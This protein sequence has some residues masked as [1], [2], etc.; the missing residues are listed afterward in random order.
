MAVSRHL[1]VS[2]A[3]G[4]LS[5]LLLT[6]DSSQGHAYSLCET[7]RLQLPG[8]P[9]WLGWDDKNAKHLVLDEA[10][11]SGFI[12]V[13]ASEGELNSSSIVDQV[14]APPGAVACCSYGGGRYLAIAH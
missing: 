4:F 3:S 2:H 13:I 11:G 12:S 8:Q 7:S 9:T 6:K 14:D 1:L 5:K 10:S